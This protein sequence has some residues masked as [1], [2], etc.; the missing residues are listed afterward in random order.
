MGVK[1]IRTLVLLISI[2]SVCIGCADLVSMDEFKASREKRTEYRVRKGDTLYS[3]SLRFDMDYRQLAALNKIEEPYHLDVGQP[4][5]IDKN[6]TSSQII[7]NNVNESVLEGE[8]SQ[9]STNLNKVVQEDVE[10]AK[11][12]WVWPL[13][14]LIIK[15]FKGGDNLNQGIEIETNTPQR[16]KAAATGTVVYVGSGIRGLGNL[17]IIKH[18]NLYLSAYAH[19]DKVFVTERQHVKVGEKIAEIGSNGTSK[20]SLLFQIR[21]EGTPVDPLIFLPKK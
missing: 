2:V 5:K 17:I 10:P 20:R 21:R 3:I 6:L 9:K 18:N 16:V 19:N 4:L 14:G 12:T 7:V 8:T 1:R 11:I 13:K 15:K